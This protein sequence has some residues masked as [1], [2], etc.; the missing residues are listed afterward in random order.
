MAQLINQFIRVHS[1]FVVP[2]RVF[3]RGSSWIT[4]FSSQDYPT[5]IFLSPG[6]LIPVDLGGLQ[7]VRAWEMGLM[8]GL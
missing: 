5:L 6:G 3:L 1:W 8:R 7:A 2:L 4:L